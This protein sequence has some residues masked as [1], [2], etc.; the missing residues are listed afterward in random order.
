VAAKSFSSGLLNSSLK[1]KLCFVP[2]S[3]ELWVLPPMSSCLVDRFDNFRKFLIWAY[4]PFCKVYIR[5]KTLLFLVTTEKHTCVLLYTRFV[6]NSKFGVRNVEFCCDISRPWYICMCEWLKRMW[7]IINWNLSDRSIV[8][9]QTNKKLQTKLKTFL[10]FAYR[11][12]WHGNTNLD[13]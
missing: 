12:T 4:L 11:K 9:I 6:C 2:V 1:L 3:D 13:G 8:V 5:F 7:K 10:S